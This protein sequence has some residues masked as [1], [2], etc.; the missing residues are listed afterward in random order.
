[1]MLAAGKLR[2]RIVLES[3]TNERD[4][5]GGVVP[6]WST[7]AGLWAEIVPLSGREFIAA[8]ATQAGVTTR[9]TI[10]WR[11][12]VSPEMRIRH[13]S[14]IYNIRAVLPDP[15]LRQ[16]ITLMCETGVNNG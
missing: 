8:Q 13:G 12:G 4:G 5:I 3:L 16:H 9:I 10:R 6:T 14:V 7:E 2:H 1:M 15:S 11:D